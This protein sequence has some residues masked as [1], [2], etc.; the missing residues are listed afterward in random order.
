M[1]HNPV[2]IWACRYNK[3]LGDATRLTKAIS[4]CAQLAKRAFWLHIPTWICMSQ[5]KKKKNVVVHFQ[6]ICFR[7]LVSSS[8]Q[9]PALG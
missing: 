6:G 3:L 4:S 8:G 2:I 1:S 5:E 9:Q 7:Q